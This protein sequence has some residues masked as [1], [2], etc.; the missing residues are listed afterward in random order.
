MVAYTLLS[1]YCFPADLQKIHLH[2]RFHLLL[3]LNLSYVVYNGS[4]WIMY[5]N[6]MHTGYEAYHMEKFE[7]A[8]NLP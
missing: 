5:S 2:L 8:D 1:A 7:G 4:T 3:F 6:R